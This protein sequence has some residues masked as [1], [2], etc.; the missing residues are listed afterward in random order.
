[1]KD[2]P[3]RASEDIRVLID[4]LLEDDSFPRA[5]ATLAANPALLTPAADEVM[6]ALVTHAEQRGDDR[7]IMISQ[8]RAFASRCRHAGLA[9]V[10]LPDHPAIDPAVVSIIG[11]DMR[12]A[13]DAERSY[14]RTGDIGALTAAAAAWRRVMTHP[15]LVSAYPGLRAALL[16]NGAGVLLRRYWAAGG[17]DDLDSAHE[18]LRTS[19]ALT[20]P[21]SPL[22]PGR[23]SNLGL[24]RREVYRNTGD[25]SMLEQALHALEQAARVAATPTTLTNLALG[26]QDRYLRAGDPDDLAGAIDCSE[27]ACRDTEPGASQVMLGDLLRLRY[28]STGHRPDLARAV[29]L[30]QAGLHAASASSPE[31]PRRLVDLGIALFDQ[32]LV[33]GDPRDLSTALQLFDEAAQAV[34]ATSPDRVGCLVHR[35]IAFYS[36]Y[37]STGSLD[38]LD[39]AADGLEEA[40]RATEA[41]SA[42]AADWTVNLAAVLHER[43]RRTGSRH[44]LNRAISLLEVVCDP[45]TAAS[46]YRHAAMN[47]LG[48]ALRD[49][50][51]VTG[52]RS[53]LDRAIL[54]IRAALQGA[55]AGSVLSATLQANLGSAH[56]DRYA[57]ARS[58]ADLDEAIR[59]LANA[60]ETSSPQDADRAR[61]LFG[62]ALATRDRYELSRQVTDLDAAIDAYQRGCAAGT[63]GDPLSTLAAAQEWGAWATE[64]RS[65]SEGATA[66]DAAIEAMLAVVRAQAT[67]EHKENWLRDTQGLPDHAAYAS[68]MARLLPAAVA[69]A[70]AGRAAIL[71]ETLQRGELDLRRLAV[72]RPDLADRYTRA[73]GRIRVAQERRPVLRRG[74]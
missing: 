52:A 59:H 51:H 29:T 3:V 16:N 19:V 57:A 69:A 43:A 74:S 25:S 68:A 50:Y 60:A 20:A 32:H 31:H 62:L 7:A 73:A 5:G 11:A 41:G 21:Q 28:Q 58:A 56:R 55:P 53:D 17:R 33:S 70:E 67:R 47:D 66:F 10:F 13:D 8:L 38:D 36:R 14:D 61:R 9:A 42:D 65:W 4:G 23:L 30:L 12:A 37:H 35:S 24:A 49:R 63:P 26:L 34:P 72:N 40:V 18:A 44:D 46:I 6:A 22:I 39:R 54:V 64:R 71:A 45:G 2:P 15:S 27:Q 1:M 48:N